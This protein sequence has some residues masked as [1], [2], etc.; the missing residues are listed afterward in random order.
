MARWR[1]IQKKHPDISEERLRLTL[2]EPDAIEKGRES[3]VYRRREEART[4]FVAVRDVRG[5]YIRTAYI[6]P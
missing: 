6:S 1:H 3:R 5:L 2:A 4:V